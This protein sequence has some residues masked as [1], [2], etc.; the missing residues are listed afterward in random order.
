MLR[1]L[2]SAEQD[3]RLTPS[4]QTA[5]QLAE[6]VAHTHSARGNRG[7]CAVPCCFAMVD[8][9]ES[10]LFSLPSHPETGYY[11]QGVKIT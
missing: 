4:L 1:C 3:R 9:V 7:N 5:L 8:T 11:G 10:L 6:M 2:E